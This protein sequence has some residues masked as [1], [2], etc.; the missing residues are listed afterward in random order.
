MSSKT[1]IPVGA[2]DDS[3]EENKESVTLFLGSNDPLVEIVSPSRTRIVIIDN[4]GMCGIDSQ[5]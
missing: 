2:T 5:L 3:I 1:C 4:D